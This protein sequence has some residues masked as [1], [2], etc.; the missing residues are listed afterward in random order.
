M[1]DI[2][3]IPKIITDLNAL[4]TIS[5]VIQDDAQVKEWSTVIEDYLL[6]NP[7]ALGLAGVQVGIPKR[8]FGMRVPEQDSPNG[9]LIIVNPKIDDAYDYFVYPNDVCLSLPGVS[10]ATRRP[11]YI[12]I[13]YH[14]YSNFN[15]PK[16]RTS[17]FSGKL[18]V[19]ISHEID[20]LN[21]KLITDIAYKTSPIG[22]NDLCPCNSGKKYKKCCEK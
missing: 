18:A 10:A 16:Q 21:G 9:V 13:T 1:E 3:D 7:R 12:R 4:H 5:E 14:D 15:D 11:M 2:K 19:C 20:H 8:I 6:A 17:T 22:R